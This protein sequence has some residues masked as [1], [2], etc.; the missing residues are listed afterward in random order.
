MYFAKVDCIPKRKR[1][2]R[3]QR[4]D[5]ISYLDGFMRMNCK[6]SKLEFVSDEYVNVNSACG[7]LYSTIHR[8]RYPII[9]KQRDNEVY[10]ERTDI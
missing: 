6:Y 10:L 4:K 2:K 9:V 8:Y 1:R 3:T 7:S 5:V